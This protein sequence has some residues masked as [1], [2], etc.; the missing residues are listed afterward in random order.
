M[1]PAAITDVAESGVGESPGALAGIDTQALD[2]AQVRHTHP[3]ASYC[4]QVRRDVD[5]QDSQAIREI[6]SDVCGAV[7]RLTLVDEDTIS[8][9]AE[10]IGRLVAKERE[11]R[12]DK[13]L[14]TAPAT[15]IAKRA[16]E[17]RAEGKGVVADSVAAQ[18]D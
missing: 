18:D 2:A 13:Q 3:F 14:W 17:L 7:A 12:G 10:H 4:E 15:K 1:S 6:V 5:L 9:Q 16:L 11:E 8:E